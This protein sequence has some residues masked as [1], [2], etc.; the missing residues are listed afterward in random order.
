MIGLLQLI[1]EVFSIVGN[2]GFQITRNS[3]T[4]SD[5]GNTSTYSLKPDNMRWRG[6]IQ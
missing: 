2:T 6:D 5:G 3:V 4:V 1:G